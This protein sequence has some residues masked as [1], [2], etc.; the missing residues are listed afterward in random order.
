MFN[1]RKTIALPLWLSSIAPFG[2]HADNMAPQNQPSAHHEQQRREYLRQAVADIQQQVDSNDKRRREM[3]ASK[4]SGALFERVPALRPFA[5]WDFFYID[6]E[7]K[8][9]PPPESLFPVVR[10]PGGFATDL[11]SVP[12]IFWSIF[13]PTGRYAWAAVVHDYL[14][15]TQ[16]VSRDDADEIIAQ[17]MR[18]LKVPDAT[19]KAFYAALRLTGGIAWSDNK[20]LKEAGERRILKVFPK[21]PLVR[22]ADWKGTAGVFR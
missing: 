18:D 1:R 3:S 19:V 5:D 9:S 6:S 11:A 14:Y 4:D 8:W 16:T 12:R 21:D 13:P 22:W 2:A 20:K 15:W 10:V 17:G 7:L